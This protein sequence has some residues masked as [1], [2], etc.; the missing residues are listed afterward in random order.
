MN[1]HDS[2]CP[3]SVASRCAICQRIEQAELRGYAKG[4]KHGRDDEK[5]ESGMTAKASIRRNYAKEWVDGYNE[6]VERSSECIDG[7]MIKLGWGPYLRGVMMNAV[8]RL[9][10]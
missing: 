3:E 9:K 1:G 2:L 4:Y 7:E 5:M 8:E 6:G 10:E